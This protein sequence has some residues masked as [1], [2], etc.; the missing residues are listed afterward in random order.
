VYADTITLSSGRQFS[1]RIVSAH[2]VWNKENP[3][4]IAEYAAVRH[5]ENTAATPTWSHAFYVQAAYR[6][7][8][9]LHQYKPYFRF[10]HVG[11]NATDAVYTGVL[12]L[13]GATVGVRYDL[14]AYAAVKA[15]YRTWTRGAGTVRNQGG[16]LQVSFTF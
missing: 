11:V 15:E 9:T 6:L 5:D 4:L 3:E 13:D 12:N 8:D 16:F 14:S 1:E 10:E 2:A 7:Q